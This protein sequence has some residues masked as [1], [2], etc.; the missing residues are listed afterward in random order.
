MM[1]AAA[2]A[3]AGTT[4]IAAMAAGSAI[5]VDTQ[6]HRAGAGT[7]A[8]DAHVFEADRPPCGAGLMR[9]IP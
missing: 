6:K 1:I 7:T 4:T 8:I 2:T 9:L 3:V 5:P